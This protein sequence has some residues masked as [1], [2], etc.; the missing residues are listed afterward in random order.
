MYI[1]LIKKTMVSH[2][3]I[4]VLAAIVGVTSVIFL[5]PDNPVEQAAE[6]VIKDETGFNV[7]LTPND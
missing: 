4:A 5:K 7:D 1:N 6:R 3:I 2:I